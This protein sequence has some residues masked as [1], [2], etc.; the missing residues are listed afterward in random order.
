MPRQ[1]TSLVS[2]FA[3]SRSGNFAMMMGVVAVPLMLAG[4]LAIDAATISSEQSRLQGAMDAASLAIAREGDQVS[5]ERATQ[6]ASDYLKANYG[7]AYT[8]LAIKRVGTRVTV[9]AKAKAPLAFGGLFGYQNWP[10]GA[11][12]SADIAYANYE[13]ALVLD[14]TGS[15]KGGKLQSMKDAVEGLVDSMSSQVKGTNRL[16]FAIV[17]FSS[18]V[19]VG[20]GHGPSFEANGVQRADGASWLDLQGL[21]DIPQVDL[22]KGVSRFRVANHLGR[23]WTGCVE[24][25]VPAGSLADTQYDINDVAPTSAR[26][27]TLF[28]PAFAPDEPDSGFY[29]SYVR[30]DRDDLDPLDRTIENRKRKLKKYG[31]P[32]KADGTPNPAKAWTSPS[33]RGQGGAGPN[34]NC[35]ARPITPLTTDFTKV[36]NEVNALAA[37]GNTNIM[38]GVA[39]G[40]RV[41]SPQPPFTEGRD[42]MATG[43]E[44]IMIVLTDGSNVMG[45]VNNVF[46]SIYSSLGYLVDG[47]LGISSGSGAQTNTAMNAKTLAACTNAKAAGMTVYT[48]RLEEPDVTTGMMLKECATSEAHFFDAPSRSDL[49]AVFKT[50]SDRIVRVR[51]AS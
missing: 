35:N 10:V 13:V 36:R 1:L 4:G 42:P 44:K 41:L 45:N 22:Q 28:V 43:V 16:K 25:R 15:M 5:D 14:T 11:V 39:W 37:A 20:P 50:I 17:P 47:R 46:G 19:N 33:T 6:I 30:N 26:P 51:I 40:M 8:D 31:I 7:G 34:A 23:K 49:D 38:E 18:F 12:A 2:R 27:E 32:Y 21:A 3:R 48:I 29:N 9:D 24:T